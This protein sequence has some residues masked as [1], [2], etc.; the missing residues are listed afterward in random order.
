M[1][2]QASQ[3]GTKP[4]TAV[5]TFRKELEDA[6]LERHC[7]HHPTTQKSARGELRRAA[8][9]GWAIEHFWL[10]CE[11]DVEHGG[12][13]FEALERYCTTRELQERAVHYARESAKMRWFYFDGIYLHYELGY[14]LR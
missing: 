7:A 11:A 2:A 9:M 13:A 14:K 3:G 1:D 8:M 5:S 4:M 6:V 12:R 10:H